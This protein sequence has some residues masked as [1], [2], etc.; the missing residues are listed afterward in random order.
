AVAERARA[1]IMATRHAALPETGDGRVLVD[2]DLSILGAGADRYAQYAAQVREEYVWVP[3]WIFRRKRKALLREFLAR[4]SIYGT[5][6]FRD[7]FEARAR[8]NLENEIRQL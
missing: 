3:G 1:L 2:V 6:Y 5:Q 8:E 4:E 7:R